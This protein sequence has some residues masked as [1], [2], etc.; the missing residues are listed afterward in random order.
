MDESLQERMSKTFDVCYIIAKENMAFRKY[1]AIHKLESC[2]G[3]DLGQIYANKD[4]SKSFTHFIAESQSNAF[5]Q[6]LSTAHFYSILMDG[7]TD[8]G[9]VEDELVVIM[10][11]HKDDKAGE[12]RSLAKYF[13]VEVPKKADTDTLITC[14]QGSL[15]THGVEN[16]QQEKRAE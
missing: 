15:S 4:S 14:F 10:T 13:S 11:S 6:S 7:T 5:I 2:H 8:A 1:P 3:I 16:L 9:T 12:I